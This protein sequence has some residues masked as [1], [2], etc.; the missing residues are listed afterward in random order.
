MSKVNNEDKVVSDRLKEIYE[1]TQHEGWKHVEEIFTRKI[2]DLENIRSLSSCSKEELF[3]QMTIH[4]NVAQCLREIL[5]EV[6]ALADAREM[7]TVDEVRIYKSE[8]FGYDL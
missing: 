8:E 7:D 4:V 1:C 5:D 2:V 3:E 6:K